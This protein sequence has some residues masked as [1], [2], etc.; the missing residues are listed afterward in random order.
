MDVSTCLYSARVSSLKCWLSSVSESSTGTFV[1]RDT[2]SKLT[3]KSP[4]F[5]CSDL[6]VS[7]KRKEFLMWCAVSLVSGLRSPD[8]CL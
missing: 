7:M 5:V 1:N 4:G 2:T 3:I 8:K 6:S